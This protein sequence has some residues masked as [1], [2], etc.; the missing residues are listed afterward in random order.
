MMTDQLLSR[1]QNRPESNLKVMAVTDDSK[2]IVLLKSTLR[3]TDFVFIHAGTLFQ[4]SSV[5]QRDHP[6]L[7]IVDCPAFDLMFRATLNMIIAER[8]GDRLP[9][10]LLVDRPLVMRARAL[11]SNDMDACLA[12]PISPLQLYLTIERLISR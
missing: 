7:I 2:L 8:N 5:I 10:I 9:L 4:A 6:S 3:L 11:I 1:S 12:K